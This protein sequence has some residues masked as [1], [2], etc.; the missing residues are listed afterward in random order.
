MYSSLTAFK[1]PLIEIP[2]EEWERYAQY[3]HSVSWEAGTGWR[4][5]FIQNLR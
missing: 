5:T 3:E 1:Y 2:D 4:W